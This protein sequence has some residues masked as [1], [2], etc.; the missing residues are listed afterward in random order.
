MVASAGQTRVCPGSPPGIPQSTEKRNRSSR[1]RRT[2]TTWVSAMFDEDA[3]GPLAPVARNVSPITV[4]S[5]AA[6][7]GAT[8]SEVRELP[9]LSAP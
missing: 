9:R 7:N 3:L 4:S 1:R 6:P 8:D 2:S 5:R